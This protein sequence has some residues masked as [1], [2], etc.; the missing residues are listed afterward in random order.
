MT[1]L[2]NGDLS[3]LAEFAVDPD[4]TPVPAPFD[5]AK[6]DY[7]LTAWSATEPA[8]TYP[9]NMVFL[10]TAAPDPGLFA[11]PNAFWTL[12]YDRTNRSRIT[13]LGDAGFAFLNTSDP[14]PDGGG[15]LGAAVLGLNASAA[16]NIFV[17]WRGGTV[18]PNER[19]CAVRLQYRSE[20]LLIEAGEVRRYSAVAAES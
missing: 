15:Y 18:T 16:Q 10:Q 12:P 14:Q 20:R 3:L 6:G 1:L 8:A 13:G 19:V 7:A 11:E 5:L 4:A 17:S 9:S 2:L